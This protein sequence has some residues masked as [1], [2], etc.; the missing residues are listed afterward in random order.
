VGGTGKLE[1][2]A[3]G[4]L[5][6]LLG[7]GSGQTADFLAGTGLLELTKPLDFAGFIEGFAAS[8]RID[9]IGAAATGFTYASGIL[10]VTDN[11]TIVAKLHFDGSYAQ[12]DFKLASDGHAGTIITFK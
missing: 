12:S 7:A 5:S 2:G 1:I 8:D 3:A 6:L 11:T 10:T 9:L 4:T